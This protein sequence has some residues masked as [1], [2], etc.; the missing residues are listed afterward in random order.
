[1]NNQNDSKKRTANSIKS[2]LNK[3][4][5]EYDFVE[6]LGDGNMFDIKCDTSIKNHQ[7]LKKQIGFIIVER[8]SKYF[9]I[10]CF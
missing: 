10:K 8:G 6:N 2:L 5:I 3:F 1:M 4:N 7:I 9:T